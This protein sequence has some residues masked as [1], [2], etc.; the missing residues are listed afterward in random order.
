MEAPDVS[1]CCQGVDCVA[2]R[3]E[4]SLPPTSCEGE[5]API[6]APPIVFVIPLTPG[7]PNGDRTALP[8]GGS[9]GDVLAV[10]EPVWGWVA[11]I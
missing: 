1:S 8:P 6:L 2:Y 7:G 9:I 4:Y 5:P 11:D 3:L 10:D